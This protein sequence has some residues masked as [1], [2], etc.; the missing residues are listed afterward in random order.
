MVHA[1]LVVED[2]LQEAAV[3]RVLASEGKALTND[4]IL[5]GSVQSPQQAGLVTRPTPVVHETEVTATRV[6]DHYPVLCEVTIR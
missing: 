6:S 4:A 1:T 2:I 3:R 5:L